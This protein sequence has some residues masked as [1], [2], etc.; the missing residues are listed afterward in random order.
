MKPRHQ[1]DILGPSFNGRTS[2][3]QA[4]NEGSTPF[5]STKIGR[6]GEMVDTHVRGAC[7]FGVRVQISSPAP[8]NCQSSPMVERRFEEPSVGGSSPPSDTN[9][10]E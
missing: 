2:A 3:L 9:T 5:G 4:E 8:S 6:S 1:L 7:A 10:Q